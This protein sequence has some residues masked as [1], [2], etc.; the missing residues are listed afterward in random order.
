MNLERHHQATLLVALAAA[1]LASCSGSAVE[2][3][4]GAGSSHQLVNVTNGFAEILPHKAYRLDSL[5]APGGPITISLRTEQLF[6]DNVTVGNPILA[7]PTFP[8]AAVL[9]SGQAGNQFLA[10]RFT[11]ALDID[12]ILTSSPGQLESNNFTGSVVVSAVDPSTGTTAIIRGRAVIN[13]YTYGSEPTGSPATLPLERWIDDD[14]QAIGFDTDDDGIAD[15]FPGLG[16]P[17]TQGAFSGSADLISPE[18]L[19]FVPDA[20]QD[21]STYETFPAGVQVTMDIKTSVRDTDGRPLAAGGVACTTVGE[22]TL[23]PEFRVGP[24]PASAPAITPARGATDVD[25][26]TNIWVEFTEP[27]QPWTVGDLLSKAIPNLSA[28]IGVAYGPSTSRVDVPFHAR[29]FSVFDLTRWE[30]IPAFNF[31]GEGPPDAN[32]G[33]FSRV[34]IE[35]RAGAASDLKG[36]TLTLPGTSFFETGEGPG[37]VNAPVTPDAVYLGR[38]GGQPGISVVDMNGFGAGTGNPSYDP[39]QPIKEGNSNFPNN[40]NV[41]FQGTTLIP[42]L[43]PGTCTVNGGSAG[44]FTLALDSTLQD[45]VVRTPII[46]SIGDMALG[47]SLDLTF[48]NAPAPFGCQGQGGNLC[49]ADGFKQVATVIDGSTLNPS[50]SNPNGTQ[51]L[52]DGGPNIVSWGPHPNPPPLAFPPLCVSPF[53]GGQEPTS[54]DTLAVATNLLQPGDPFGDPATN[55]PPSGL[56]ANQANVF[57]QGPSLPNTQI[58]ACSLY[59]LRQQ[60]GQFLY[61]VDRSRNEI[62]V[63]NSN[64]MTVVDRIV[65]PDPTSL[66]SGSN[67][68]LLAVTSQSSD[69]V[70]FIDTNPASATFHQIVKTVSVGDA[71]RGIAWEPGN[72]DIIVCN[73][74][75]SSISLISAFSLAVRKTLVASLD[76]P[77]EVAI[78]PRQLSFGLSRN[79]YFA[80]VL[81]RNG[82]VA[83]FESGPNGVNGWGYDDIVGTIPLEFRNPKTIQP[84][85]L[86]LRSG[87]WIVHEGP[88]DPITQQ[89]GGSPTEGALTNVVA[90]SG[91]NGPVPLS[92]GSLLTPQLRDI[93]YDVKVSLGQERL[94]GVPV[95]VAFDNMTNAGGIVNWRTNFSA[96]SAVPLNGK[97]IVRQAG[98]PIPTNQPRFMLAAVPSPTLGLGGVDVILLDGAYLRFDTN[99]FEPGIQSIE[100]PGTSI[101]MD[102]WRQ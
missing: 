11:H 76:R 94:T 3:G 32:C 22:D 63:L 52:I 45:K 65:V 84:D 78:T 95:D 48:N 69:S 46:Q 15:S 100:A 5:N 85:P 39:A 1:G 40:P 61:V 60:I 64:R 102:Y 30:L 90:V 7:A 80:Y 58:A 49:G 36:N 87:L 81:N 79:V 16:F 6:L 25:P 66:A 50:A 71:P 29:P 18:V 9:P 54:I 67:V 35:L 4:A 43:A 14:G 92:V 12:S 41:R 70:F 24:P 77:F 101:I 33:V 68:D 2:G 59:G 89:L 47:Y 72:E 86:D 55:T 88:L 99:Q 57:F 93:A 37:L 75:D 44:V 10:A 62:V 97:A 51:I 74:G 31:P 91:T 53:I 17:G 27:M 23:A 28:S 56:L 19:V 34:D 82:R 73:E 20:D 21:L 13:G 96:G 26:L 8:T 42:P 38:G 98:G 83:V